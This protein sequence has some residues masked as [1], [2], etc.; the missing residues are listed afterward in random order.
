MK[1]FNVRG[2]VDIFVRDKTTL[3]IIGEYHFPNLFLN[4][5]R[6]LLLDQMGFANNRGKNAYIIISDSQLDPQIDDVAIP[7]NVYSYSP[8]S[9]NPDPLFVT[10]NLTV[11]KRFHQ[12]ISA[13]EEGVT[14]NVGT[15][16]IAYNVNGGD[17]FCF[18]KLP[19]VIPQTHD[20]VLEVFYTISLSPYS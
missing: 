4:N 10:E 1:G 13:P 15:V 17:A 19:Q 16:G 14:R 5:G 3:K 2:F 6:K 7:G 12:Q 11:T 18:C 9:K 20:I 8:Q